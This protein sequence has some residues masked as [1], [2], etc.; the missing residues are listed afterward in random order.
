MMSSGSSLPSGRPGTDAEGR[1]R[2]EGFRWDQG[3]GS[4]YLQADVN[5]PDFV[6]FFTFS[7]WEPAQADKAKGNLPDVQL[8]RGNYVTGRCIGPDGKAVAG[9]KIEKIFA[10]F[11]RNSRGRMPITDAEGRFRLTIPAGGRRADH[12]LRP[13]GAPASQRRAADGVTW[14]T[15][16]SRRR[17]TYRA[18]SEPLERVLHGE[19]SRGGSD[20]ESLR[21]GRAA[22]GGKGN[23]DREH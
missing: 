17:R 4:V 21:P 12:L 16:G 1:Y 5:A 19:R 15:S 13:M 7:F 20:R 3:P 18:P 23:R 2:I 9:A 8:K 10:G 14:A 22:P 11:A 6:E